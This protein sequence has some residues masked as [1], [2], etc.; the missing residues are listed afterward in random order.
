MPSTS[1]DLEFHM[2]DVLPVASHCNTEAEDETKHGSNQASEVSPE[3]VLAV[4]TDPRS[5]LLLPSLD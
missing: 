2:A 3:L 1:I 4:Q 5:G